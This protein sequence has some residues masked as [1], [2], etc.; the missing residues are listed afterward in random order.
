MSITIGRYL[1]IIPLFNVY[2]FAG[3]LVC[4]VCTLSTRKVVSLKKG[5]KA[6]AVQSSS[7]GGCQLVGLRAVIERER[8]GGREGERG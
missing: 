7:Q 2:T 4:V 1:E 5:A 3:A 8:E 6:T